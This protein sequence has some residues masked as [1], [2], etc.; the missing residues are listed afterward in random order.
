MKAYRSA[1]NT[2]FFKG[3]DST[4]SLFIY[5][6]MV[7]RLFDHLEKTLKAAL[8]LKPKILRVVSQSHLINQKFFLGAV[9]L[10]GRVWHMFLHEIP[11][12]K[13]IAFDYRKNL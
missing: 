8:K 6:P 2:W 4:V 13:K 5:V 12:F 1:K 11:A 10:L 7:T 9:H 3:N